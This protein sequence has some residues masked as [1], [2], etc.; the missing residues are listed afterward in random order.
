MAAN[1]SRRLSSHHLEGPAIEF[2]EQLAHGLVQHG[3][4]KEG[5]MP[6]VCQ[7]PGAVLSLGL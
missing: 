3:Q 4:G 1:R 5:V 2:V 6:Q 7:D